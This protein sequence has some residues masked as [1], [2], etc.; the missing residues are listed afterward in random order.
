MLGEAF[1]DLA[2]APSRLLDAG[3]GSIVLGTSDGVVFR[4]ARTT[5]TAAGHEVEARLLPWL[6]ERVAVEIPVPGWRVEP[7]HEALEFGAIGSRRLP[8]EPMSPALAA[9]RDSA[10]IA[11]DVARFLR[12]LHA[13]SVEDAE[14]RGAPRAPAW[15]DRVRAL[16]QAVLPALHEALSPR[17]YGIVERWLHDGGADAGMERCEP[18]LRHGDLWFGNLLVGREPLRLT[19]VLD[20]EGVAVGDPAEDLAVQ[21][22]L[23]PGFAAL[24]RSSYAAPDALFDHR[25]RRFWEIR[26]FSGLRWAIEQDNT[27]EL[28]DSV[29]KLR[30]GAILTASSRRN[31]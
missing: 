14:A 28:V 25:V 22:H 18:T 19:A 4:I 8:G 24:V 31:R 20:W 12:S 27:A 13:I 5:A 30:S 9:R 2:V 23:G 11:S 29:A 3:F 7:G 17:E 6:A 1:P 16:P 26:E 10:R 15:P 21:H